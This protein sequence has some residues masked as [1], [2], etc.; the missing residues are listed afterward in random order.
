MGDRWAPYGAAAG[1]MA[2]A[3]FLAAALVVGDQPAFDASGA[4]FAAHLEQKQTRIQVACALYALMAPFLI[5]FLA[6]VVSLT[7]AGPA[8]AQ[9]ASRVAFGCGLAFLT[10]FLADVTTL[11]VGALRPE[12]LA[13]APELATALRDF[14]WM[15]IG[16]A[17]PLGV[18]APCRPRGDRA[19]R[20]EWS[21]HAGSAGSPR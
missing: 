14:E 18:R 7:G 16:M 20:R 21:G 2:I 19:A 9:R 11:A 10:L 3:L 8:G 17:T 12:N 6:T 5:W 4:E 15:A 1:G 13:A